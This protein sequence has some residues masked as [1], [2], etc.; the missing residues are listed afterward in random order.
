MC[1]IWFEDWNSET[2]L[3]KPFF[4]KLQPD[5]E[6]PQK[7]NSDNRRPW[8]AFLPAIF[9]RQECLPHSCYNTAIGPTTT[10]VTGS[11]SGLPSW[12]SYDSS[13]AISLFSA[14]RGGGRERDRLRGGR[15]G[16]GRVAGRVPSMASFPGP[17]SRTTCRCSGGRPT[18][19]G[20]SS[21]SGFTSRGG[22]RRTCRSGKFRVT[23]DRDFAGVIRGCATAGDG[24][25]STWLT[26]EMIRAYRAAACTW[27]TPIASK[28]GATDRLAGGVYG[29]RLADCSPASR[30]FTSSATRRKSRLA[31]WCGTCDSAGYRLLDMQQLNPH[32]ASMGGI[33]RFLAA[34]ICGG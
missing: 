22:W 14:G 5:F 28:F 19:G 21:S 24:T 6:P 33:A 9:G 26:D 32:T 20:S 18:R 10:V 4:E 27:V 30:C 8:Q 2:R 17:C 16:T 1:T 31:I 23:S 25:V 7:A 3:G 11:K 15:T 13:T 12:L 29:V 34:S